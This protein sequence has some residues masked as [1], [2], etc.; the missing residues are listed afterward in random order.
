[1]LK[2]VADENFHGAVLRALRLR[3]PAM[4]VVRVVDV[5]LSGI[6]D[7]GLLA[8]AAE[9]GRVILTHDVETLAGFALARLQAGELMS[10]VI[11][12]RLGGAMRRIVD[13]V[14]LIVELAREDEVAGNIIFVPFST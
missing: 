11:E 8:W 10:G 4:D 12:V 6:S 3:C 7:P 14:L 9:N 1:M 13:D 5:G 2:I